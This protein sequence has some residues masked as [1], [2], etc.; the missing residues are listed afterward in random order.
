MKTELENQ[1][2]IRKYEKPE[3]KKHESMN[4][5]QGSTLYSTTLYSTTLYS[6]GLYYTSLYYYY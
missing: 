6:G 2:V 1:G 4:I 3:T 5:V